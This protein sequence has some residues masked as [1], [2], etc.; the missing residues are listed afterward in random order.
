MT[1]KN[2]G[3]VL[4]L[5]AISFSGLAQKNKVT[6][7]ALEYNKIDGLLYKQDF[8]GA[9]A[10]ATTAKEYIDESYEW[11]KANPTEKKI[12][13]IYYYKGKIYTKLVSIDIA[14]NAQTPENINEE[15]ITAY[16]NT[17][18]TAYDEGYDLANKY[19]R[20]IETSAK[21]TA[22]I[23]SF[24]ANQL[25]EAGEYGGAGEAFE[26]AGKCFS[27]IDI[28]DSNYYYNA[29]LSYRN[30]GDQA[31]KE[32]EPHKK[33]ADMADDLDDEMRK[34]KLEIVKSY[35]DKRDE[36][37]KKG[38]RAFEVLA[39]ADYRGATGAVLA[40]SCYAGAKDFEKAHATLYAAEKKFPGNLDIL[41]QRVDVYLA[42]END[43][44]AMKALDDA[45]AADPE[46]AVLY[47]S[48]GSI[49][50]KLEN[51]EEAEK[52]LMKSLELD[53]KNVNTQYQL[54][55]LL[56]NWSGVLAVEAKNLPL[57]DPNVS[58]TEQKA[59][60]KMKDAIKYLEMYLES[61]P[62]DKYVLDNLYKAHYKQGNEEK[63][64]EYKARLDA[65]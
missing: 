63:S 39:K 35:L 64:K 52:A 36:M 50:M 42:Q 2:V 30:A 62:N 43:E 8:A 10:V 37:Y 16:F 1:L 26:M 49:Q 5:T 9:K 15:E 51:Y 44:A 32:A 28:L 45:I 40:A 47:Y 54:G 21:E 19:K 65:L 17:A 3:L 57:G 34:E 7:A 59:D 38:A 20:D 53:G 25:Y 6:D 56:Y 13:K 48:I 24:M 22:G 41:K 61:E 27:A 29:G 60:Q 4:G 33:I 23:M 55:A 46:N 12:D 31:S 58:K 18:I 11:A 14:M